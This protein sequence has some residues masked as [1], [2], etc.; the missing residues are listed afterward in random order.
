MLILPE[1]TDCCYAASVCKVDCEGF[2]F[3]CNFNQKCLYTCLPS[4][5]KIFTKDSHTKKK[6]YHRNKKENKTKMALAVTT[7]IK[8]QVL[9]FL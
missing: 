2:F 9:L 5:E 4:A 1:L 3:F 7:T 8:L 6:H